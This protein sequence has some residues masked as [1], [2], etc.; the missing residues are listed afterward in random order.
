MLHDITD[1]KSGICDTGPCLEGLAKSQNPDA[2]PDEVARAVVGLKSG[3]DY[4][5]TPFGAG[6]RSCIGALFSLLSVTTIIGKALSPDC[7]LIQDIIPLYP[8][9]LA[10]SFLAWPLV[11]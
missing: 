2:T 10:S 3:R 11:P 6:P 1:R 5:Y 8:F 7:L 4:I 9:T